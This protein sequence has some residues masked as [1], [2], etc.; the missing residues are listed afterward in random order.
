MDIIDNKLCFVTIVHNT[1]NYLCKILLISDDKI[2]WSEDYHYK[3]LIYFKKPSKI[4]KTFNMLILYSKN[5]KQT[6]NL[7]FSNFIH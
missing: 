7:L 2:Y 5:G 1:D 4:E 3:C 6:L